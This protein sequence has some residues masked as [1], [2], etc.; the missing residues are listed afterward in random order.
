MPDVFFGTADEAP[1]GLRELLVKDDATGK[2]KINV[3]PNAK[4]VEFRENNVALLQERDALKSKVTKFSTVVGDDPDKFQTEL[5]DLRKL[6]EQIKDGTVKGTDAIQREVDARV[7]AMEESYKTQLT[8]LGNKLK[9][10]EEGRMTMSEKYRSSVRDR[11][12]TDAVLAGDSGIN[13]QALPDILSRAA[14]LFQ[15]TETGGL[16]AK[17]G[18]TVIYG[19][20][21]ASPMTPKE[22]LA[23]LLEEAPYLGKSS[24]GGGAAGQQGA[25]KI[26]GMSEK[27]F[28]ALSPTRRMQLYREQASKR[29]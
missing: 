20:D 4:L 14:G 5:A 13:P 10:T 12:I 6:Q 27:D 2:F 23:K 29:A 1:E 17:K 9:V 3:V 15:V 22:W 19:S 18:D 16:V 24:A 26:A 8:E 11:G 25:G 21:G 7:K 28:A